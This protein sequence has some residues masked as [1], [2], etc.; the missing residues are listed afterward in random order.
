MINQEIQEMA[1]CSHRRI[2]TSP[3]GDLS[4]KSPPSKMSICR[5]KMSDI[6]NMTRLA[7]LRDILKVFDVLCVVGLGIYLVGIPLVHLPV[8]IQ[9]LLH[10]WFQPHALW[11]LSQYLV[12]FKVCPVLPIFLLLFI[13][14]WPVILS[15]LFS[16][17][18]SD[19][20]QFTNLVSVDGLTVIKYS[21]FRNVR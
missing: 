17:L 19:L 14:C 10:M 8:L 21:E 11:F 13:Y 3:I 6:R 7:L 2:I 4:Q 9:N 18:K 16:F 5:S 12:V 20:V 1:S 15:L